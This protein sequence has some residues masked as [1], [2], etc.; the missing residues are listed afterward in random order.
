LSISNTLRKIILATAALLLAVGL[1][2]AIGH[3]LTMSSSGDCDS[4]NVITCGISDSSQL[5]Q[6]AKPSGIACL[7]NHFG[8]TS[9][10]INNFDSQAVSGTV[11]KSGNVLVNGRVVATD[12]MTAGRQNIAGSMRFACGNH[13]FF[14]RPPS[15]SFASSSLPAFVVMRG[16]QFDFAIIASCGNPVMATP[17]TP[18]TPVTVAPI[19]RPTQTQTQSQTVNVNTPAPVVQSAATSAPAPVLP[20]TGA[21]SVISIFAGMTIL[22]TLGHWLFTR[23]RVI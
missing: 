22:G 7:F 15:V 18:K 19:V 16:G 17:T 13:G 4:N 8:I 2:P 6:A 12:A 10:D 14:I 21:G 9:Q 3:G 11:T 5:A 1:R 20:N 23:R